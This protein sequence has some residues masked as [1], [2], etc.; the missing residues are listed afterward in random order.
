MPFYREE[1]KVVNHIEVE[2]VSKPK[3]KRMI[4]ENEDETEDVPEKATEDV[5]KVTKHGRV[6]RKPS[7]LRD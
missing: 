7:K 4:I 6:I 5:E 3:P 1:L 2:R